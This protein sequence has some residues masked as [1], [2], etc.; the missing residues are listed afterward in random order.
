MTEDR[1]PWSR[2]RPP[3]HV[4]DGPARHLHGVGRAPGW[5][6]LGYADG[7]LVGTSLLDLFRDDPA[8]LASV[9]RALAGD[10]FTVTREVEGRTLWVYYQA[11]LDAT[12]LFTG[13]W[14]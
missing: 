6:A 13:R 11:L 9:H 5:P 3:G 14:R 7:E 2:G 1:T 8:V 4:R 12:G 10:T